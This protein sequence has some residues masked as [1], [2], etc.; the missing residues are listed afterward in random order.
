[1]IKTLQ[2]EKVKERLERKTHTVLSMPFFKKKPTA[3]EAAKAAKRQTKREVR[4]SQR[5]IEREIRDL[6]KQEKQLMMEIKQRAKQPGVKGM[7][8]PSLKS[9]AKN[10]VQIRNQ[11]TKLYETK[12]QLGGIAMQA[13]SMATQVAASSA[14][15]N[16]TGAMQAV[17]S[18]VDTTDMMKIMNNFERE[19]EVMTV[20]QEMMDDALTDVFDS[21]GVE[22]E[23]DQVTDQVLAELGIE[24]DSKMV[25]LEAPSNK[26]QVQQ[27]AIVEDTAVADD[28]KARLDAL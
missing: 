13:T 24:M 1:V 10:L 21:E 27:P 25:G 9:M 8:D 18:A 4:S 28:L 26:V 23:A 6:E 19:T 14:I 22:E 5:D 12:Y 2:K 11:R 15:G 3:N 17:N 7:N 20:R 16:V